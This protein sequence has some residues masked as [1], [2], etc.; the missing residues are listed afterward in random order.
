MAT[1]P[2]PIAPSKPHRDSVLALIVKLASAMNVELSVLTQD[3]YYQ[4]LV[5]LKLDVLA[6]A[7]DRLIESWTLPH[8]MP[9][10]A[11]ILEYVGIVQ[12]EGPRITDSRHILDRGD[13]PP[14]WEPLNPGEMEA[15]RKEA[16]RRTR[17]I[18]TQVKTAAEE[19]AVPPGIDSAEWERRRDAQLRTFREQNRQAGEA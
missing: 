8:V 12:A 2:K 11:T 18:E 13:K 6:R 3:V 7:I 10:I 17:E 5:T 9:P 4:K 1:N 16:Q 15:M 19:K 14:D